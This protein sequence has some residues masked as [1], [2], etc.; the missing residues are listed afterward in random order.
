MVVILLIAIVNIDYRISNVLKSLYHYNIVGVVEIKK[1]H[2]LV[3]P[4][5]H[6]KDVTDGFYKVQR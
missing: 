3:W 1:K 5:L 2:I 6:T 4:T